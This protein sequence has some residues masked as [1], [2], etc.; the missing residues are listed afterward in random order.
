M[1][2][3]RSGWQ[4]RGPCKNAPP[5]NTHV[6]CGNTPQ[7]PRHSPSPFGPRDRR[8]LSLQRVTALTDTP[9]PIAG[10][11]GSL[12]AG[13]PRFHPSPAAPPALIAPRPLPV[14]QRALP[15][16]PQSPSLRGGRRRPPHSN[17]RSTPTR[18]PSRTPSRRRSRQQ[19][20]PNPQS[21][22]C[23]RS[24]LAIPRWEG[25]ETRTPRGWLDLRLR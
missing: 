15:P 20:R 9:L 3:Q 25:S 8:A 13:S 6:A 24:A 1:A 12:P 4:G 16:P 17:R 18:R 21:T 11:F 22:S 19:G 14:A 2:G 10:S 5:Y 7:G 23:S